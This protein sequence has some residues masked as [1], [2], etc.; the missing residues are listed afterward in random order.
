MPYLSDMDGWATPLGETKAHPL[1]WFDEMPSGAERALS[2]GHLSFWSDGLED[3]AD[4]MGVAPLSLAHR[5]H[6]RDSGSEELLARIARDDI[7]AVRLDLRA[8]E[9][10][11]MTTCLPV[12]A[13]IIPGARHGEIDQ[14]QGFL[15]K[16]LKVAF[17]SLEDAVLVDALL[18][19]REALLNALVHGCSCKP[20]RYAFLQ[21]AHDIKTNMLHLSIADDGKGHFFDFDKHENEAAESLIPEHR[22]LVLMK[23]LADRIHISARGNRLSMD[24]PLI[25][26]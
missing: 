15:G 11:A 2:G 16:S 10:A 3:V 14:I 19:I 4:R 5:L 9:D 7:V 25:N 23:N 18:C 13:E 6:M 8:R 17:P 21:A 20:D 22:G 12:L 24:F 26:P 1:G